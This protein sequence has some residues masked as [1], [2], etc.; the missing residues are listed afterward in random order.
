MSTLPT[1]SSDFALIAEHSVPSRPFLI[2]MAKPLHVLADANIPLAA[3]AFGGSGEVRLL[4]GE[5]ITSDELREIDVLLVRSVTAID[6]ALLKGSP[7]K[8]VGT[9]TAGTDHIDED[10]LRQAGIE[11]TSAAGSNTT[12]VVEYTLA[13]LLSTAAAFGTGLR[14]LTLG[15]VGCGRIGGELARRVE[16]LGMEVLRCDPP[17]HEMHP[18]SP[19][20]VPQEEVLARSDIIT[21]HTPLTSADESPHP[22]F[23]LIG[24]AELELMKPD[25]VLINTAR[26]GV[27]DNAALKTALQS[28]TISGTVLDVWEDEPGIDVELADLTHIATPHIA[29]YSFDGKVEGTRMLA[30]ALRE[31]LQRQGGGALPAWDVEAALRPLQGES[32]TLHAL[33]V[34]N[35]LDVLDEAR[36]LNVLVRQAY[37]LRADDTRFRR[38]VLGAAPPGR[39]AAFR[40]LRRTYPVRRTW[41][42][43]SVKTVIPERLRTVVKEGLGME[44][45]M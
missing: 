8:F 24:P 1:C 16:A 25:A 3:A 19:L 23:H 18:K 13:A 21:L 9:A 38:N 41:S 12:S 29:G 28:A 30:E 4:P 7:V 32:L 6:E 10:F 2:A 42:R 26:G 45:V 33:P 43:I 31:W 11:F 14:G 35:D 15:V 39:A 17:L 37:N 22:T 5:A 40:E 27:V 36:W 34:E 20:Y 44:L